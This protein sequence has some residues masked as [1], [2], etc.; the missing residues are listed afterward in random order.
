MSTLPTNNAVHVTVPAL[1]NL[2]AEGK[3]LFL[4]PGRISARQSG[5][6]L[7]S[8]KGRGMEFDESRPYQPGDDVRHLDWRVT[9][10][11]GKAHSKMFREEQERPVFLWVD[12]RVPMQFATQGK[13]KSV[14][15]AEIAGLLAWSAT[16]NRDRIGGIIFS[17]Q[18]H[19]ELK[20]KRGNSAVLRLIN[21]LAL[22]Q[23]DVEIVAPEKARQAGLRAMFRLRR[24]AKPG[25][26][27][28]L[29]SDFRHFDAIAESQLIQLGRHSDVVIVL[30]YDPLESALPP[31]GQYQLSNGQ[32]EVLLNTYDRQR[33]DNY[34]KKFMAHQ[35]R[36]RD[37]SRQCRMPFLECLTTDKPIEILQRGLGSKIKQTKR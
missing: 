18:V 25:S 13:F 26:L 32:Q 7:S 14:I 17:E 9:A 23:T 3:K 29:M 6:Y 27:I 30:V 28:F 10:R 19:H 37:I 33:V 20:P 35:M 2:R 1:L 21:Q 36:L 4:M 31:A 12:Q 5:D 15:A 16:Y 34:K 8:F 24:L 22:P 11:T